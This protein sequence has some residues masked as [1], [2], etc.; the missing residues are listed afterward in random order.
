MASILLLG[1]TS[2]VF[3]QLEH[4]QMSLQA[5][6]GTTAAAAFAD[7]LSVWHKQFQ[8]IETVLRTWISVQQLW[9]QLEQV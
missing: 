5:L 3:E 6:M 1:H 8:T 7:D 2:G 4:H 9:V